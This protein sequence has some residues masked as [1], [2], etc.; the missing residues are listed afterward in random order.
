MLALDRAAPPC[1]GGGTR[2]RADGGV[3]S[4]MTFEGQ[5]WQSTGAFRRTDAGPRARVHGLEDEMA[6][7]EPP[8]AGRSSRRGISVP[9]MTSE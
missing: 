6:S 7:H 8:M 1:P 5:V 3:G 4:S 2:L 9:G